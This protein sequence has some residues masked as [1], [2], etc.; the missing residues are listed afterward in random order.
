MGSSVILV[1]HKVLKCRPSSYVVHHET[2]EEL[3]ET[4]GRKSFVLK[5]R[6]MNCKE[7]LPEIAHKYRVSIRDYGQR[8][9]M[10]L[11]DVLK[12]CLFYTS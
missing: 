8:K 1:F 10:M 6:G 2:I 12:K 7:L 3:L 11:Y 5:F 9:P 4:F